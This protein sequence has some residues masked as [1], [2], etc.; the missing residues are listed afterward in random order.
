MTEHHLQRPN[1]VSPNT[2]SKLSTIA[3]STGHKSH[4]H[5]YVGLEITHQATNVAP[6]ITQPNTNNR[7]ALASN[8]NL[9][10]QSQGKLA[11]TKSSYTHTQPNR[12]TDCITQ[13]RG[14]DIAPQ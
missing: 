11:Y 7:M 4:H 2:S 13:V 3:L 14:Q 10:Q 1:E 9:R 12:I 5:K 8:Q 6:N